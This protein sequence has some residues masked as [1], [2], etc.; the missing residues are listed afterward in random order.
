M[1]EMDCVEQLSV[2]ET[3]CLALLKPSLGKS[4]LSEVKSVKTWEIKASSVDVNRLFQKSQFFSMEPCYCKCSLDAHMCFYTSYMLEYISIV[5][6]SW[7]LAWLCSAF[8]Q[9]CRLG[10]LG[11]EPAVT[12]SELVGLL[13]IASWSCEHRHIIQGLAET[14]TSLPIS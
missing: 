14:P 5:I 4:A 12:C 11:W 6:H 8:S 7:S 2:N 1:L 10:K 13:A 9:A 3:W